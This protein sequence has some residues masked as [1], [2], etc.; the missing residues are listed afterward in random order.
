MKKVVFSLLLLM[1]T[2]TIGVFAQSSLVATLIHNDTIFTAY[3]GLHALESAYNASV[4]GDVITLSSGGFNAPGFIWKNITIRGVGMDKDTVNKVVPTILIGDFITGS[5]PGTTPYNH[6]TMEG[7][8]HDGTLSYARDYNY[9]GLDYALFVR[10][11]F[12]E[13]TASSHSYELDNVK[14]IQ[15]KI[16]N[17]TA[18]GNATFLN[19]YVGALGRLY[20]SS[21]DASQMNYECVNCVVYG[22]LA[23]AHVN[24][25]TFTNCVLLGNKVLD[26]SNM[27]YNCIGVYINKSDSINNLFSNVPDHFSNVCY[28]KVDEVFDVNSF[29]ANGTDY[30]SDFDTYRLLDSV[31]T[32]YLGTDGTE[33]GMYGGF[34]PFSRETATSPRISKFV[35]DRKSSNGKLKV[36]VEVVDGADWVE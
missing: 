21:N 1:A 36:E 22:S 12:N 4:D 10:C 14:F 2:S 18:T 24:H 29:D 11:R 17:I 15:C 34:Y 9:D 31:R 20:T 27:A 32:K 7:I 6:L 25:S 8:W 33:I 26:A 13:I 23:N 28:R 19:C 5:S 16:R 3:Y 30:Y 35:V